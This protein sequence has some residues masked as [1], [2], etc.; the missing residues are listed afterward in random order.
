MNLR[1]INRYYYLRF[2]RLK[3]DPALLAGGTAIGVFV[4]LTPTIPFHTLLVIGMTVVSR[5]STIAGILSSWVVC[6]P[7]TY[8]PIYYFSVRFG[9]IFTANEVSWL[10]I[11][12][13]IDQLLHSESIAASLAVLGNL[14]YETITVMISG[15]ILF[16]LPISLL[17]YF[18]ALYFFRRSMKVN[19]SL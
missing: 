16:A 10:K 17:S 14:G 13:V 3:G 9:N 2:K 5:T 15:S 6:N 4:G 19:K 11:R 7:L 18:I 8:F 12:T 1:R